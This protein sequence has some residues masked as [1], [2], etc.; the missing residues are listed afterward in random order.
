MVKGLLLVDIQNDYFPGG[1]MELVGSAE[2]GSQARELLA[3]FRR[4]SLPVIHVQ[5]I[6][7]HPGATF[8]LPQTRGVE[9]NECV[10]PAVNEITVRKSFPNSFRE[11]PLL[12]HLR[13]LKVAEL[14]IAGMMTHMCI[15]STTRAA[16]DLG[17]ECSLAHNACAAKALS[18]GGITVPAPMVHAAFLASLDGSFAKVLAVN[19]LCADLG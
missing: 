14:I 15:D 11:T 3:A 10:T 19:D 12:R 13:Q 8:F 5:H 4:R 18:T 1:A 9:I 17:F 6:A 7:L 16:F 2:A